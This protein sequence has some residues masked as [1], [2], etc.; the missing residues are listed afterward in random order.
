MPPKDDSKTPLRR[1]VSS[2]RD[3]KATR[4]DRHS[5]TDFGFAFADRVDYLDPLKWDAVAAQSSFFL[6]AKI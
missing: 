2:L 6:R 5:A 3:L 4:K 1:V